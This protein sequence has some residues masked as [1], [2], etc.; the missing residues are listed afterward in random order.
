MEH[1]T[2][3]GQCQLVWFPFAWSLFKDSSSWQKVLLFFTV[4]FIFDCCQVSRIMYRLRCI[5][6]LPSEFLRKTKRLLRLLL[7]LTAFPFY[8]SKSISNGYISSNGRSFLLK[9][10]VIF[11]FCYKLSYDLPFRMASAFSGFHYIYLP[12]RRLHYQ[13]LDLSEILYLYETLPVFHWWG[14][15]FFQAFRKKIKK[16]YHKWMSCQFLIWTKV[17]DKAQ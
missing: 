1:L 14:H 9:Q 10:N 13:N 16:W 3:I 11:L 2:T 8:E 5:I 4:S 17:K 6:I 12:L 15:D 7:H